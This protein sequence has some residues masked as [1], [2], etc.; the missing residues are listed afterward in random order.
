[1]E[2]SISQVNETSA[3]DEVPSRVPRVAIVG[4]PNVGKSTVFNRLIRRRKAIESDIAGTTRDRVSEKL[5]I[6]G[7]RAELIDTAGI[8][9]AGE[10]GK[11]RIKKTLK[12]I[13]K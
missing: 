7:L 2:T 11:L 13:K 8:D 1:M 10:L 5:F 3:N 6:D 12:V 9:D 4:R